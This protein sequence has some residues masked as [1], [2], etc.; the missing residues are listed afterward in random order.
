MTTVI[1]TELNSKSIENG[2]P[3]GFISRLAEHESWRKEVYRPIYYLHKWWARRLGSVFRA[4]ILGSSLEKTED[5]ENYFYKPTRLP[6]TVIFDPFMGSG[7]TIGEAVKLGCKVIGRDINPVS[8]IMVSTAL[9]SYS[10]DEV[11]A[12]FDHISNGVGE[13]IRSFY[14]IELPN[15]EKAE[16]LYYFWVKVVPCLL[17]GYEVELFKSRIFS[18]NAT[19]KKHPA[20]KA[21]CPQCK[22]INDLNYNDK[23]TTCHHCHITYNPQIGT[24]VNKKVICPACHGNFTVINAVRKLSHPPCH[25]IYAKMV[26]TEHGEKIYLSANEQDVMSYQSVALLL[27]VSNREIPQTAI[28]AGYNT[29]QILNYNYRYWHDLFN[30]RQ[31]VCFALLSQEIRK[32]EKPELRALFACLLSS[33]LEFNNLFCSFKGEGTG[34]VRPIFAHHILKPELTPIE[35]NIWGT[36]KS[37]GSFSTLFETRIVRALE[38]KAAPFEFTLTNN[39]HEKQKN[40]KVFGLSEPIYVNISNNYNNFVSRNSVYLSVGDSSRTDIP[41]ESVDF[42]ITDPPF[43]DNVHYSQLADFFYVWL[44]NILNNTF[45]EAITTRSNQEVQ[46]IDADK[47]A[48]KLMGVFKE[49]QRVLKAAGLLVFTYHH[50]RID[51]WLALYRA[52]RE[53]GFYVTRVHPIKSEMAV[54]I[55]IQQSKI[56]IN[57]DLIMVCRKTSLVYSFSP[58]DTIHVTLCIDETRQ[59]TKELQKVGIQVSESDIKVIFLG[60]VLSKLSLIGDISKEIEFLAT[61]ERQSETFIKEICVIASPNHGL[62]D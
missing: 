39:G 59:M 48:H 62:A 60:S 5:I 28:Q 20:A 17:C 42:V 13:K 9:Q 34:A 15:G 18:K 32:I 11:K 10:S 47:F 58:N 46:D 50:S 57:I 44:H 6:N 45:C 37:S 24:V 38:Y 53:S 4:I 29:N 31:L 21:I 52:I 43:F 27:N 26:L 49:C 61:I 3:I 56:P 35:A 30:A 36:P 7:T 16:V 25:K 14:T 23:E 8:L 51:G 55:S 41:S 12:T 1:E 2:F 33:T 19:P 40:Q 54:A 22:S